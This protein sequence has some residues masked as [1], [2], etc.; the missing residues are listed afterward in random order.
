L[1]ADTGILWACVGRYDREIME[2]IEKYILAKDIQQL[3][4]Y[5]WNWY[6]L[7]ISELL[8]IKALLPFVG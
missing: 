8:L 1:Y 3:P 4:E 7:A 5:K 6:M 2:L